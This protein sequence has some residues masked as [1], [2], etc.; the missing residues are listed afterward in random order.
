LLA[1]G[2]DDCIH[3]KHPKKSLAQASPQRSARACSRG[4]KI[5]IRPGD[6]QR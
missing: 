2:F 5:H 3:I 1:A 4:A 6:C